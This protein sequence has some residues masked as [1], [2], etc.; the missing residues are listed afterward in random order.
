VNFFN[1]DIFNHWLIEDIVVK[2]VHVHNHFY[3]MRP[4]SYRI[5]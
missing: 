4:E 5:R 2:K 1:D 3:A